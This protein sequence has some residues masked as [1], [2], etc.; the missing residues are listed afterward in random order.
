MESN[1]KQRGV[2]FFVG[3][4]AVAIVL[5]LGV[6]I[7][8]LPDGARVDAAGS[9]QSEPRA[10]VFEELGF[11]KV[12]GVDS[13]TGVWGVLEGADVPKSVTRLVEDW[14]GDWVGLPSG[15]LPRTDEFAA[16]PGAMWRVMLPD[17]LE[18]YVLERRVVTV[19]VESHLYFLRD[20]VTDAVSEEPTAVFARWIEA[21]VGKTPIRLHL[22]NL[23]EYADWQVAVRSYTHNGTIQDSE[24]VSFLEPV[25]EGGQPR[26]ARV[27]EYHLSMEWPLGEIGD[28]APGGNY[29]TT[30][31][32]ERNSLHFETWYEN[33]LR[34][35]GRRA[36]ARGS[37]QRSAAGQPFRRIEST[38]FDEYAPIPE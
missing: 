28:R 37:L 4:F 26:L 32:R 24:F 23:D 2:G 13:R 19:G 31:I 11:A 5:T 27:L 29:V 36:A 15:D 30:L 22:V 14:V 34:A 1:Q 33:P 6:I 10:L 16:R 3:A 20:S 7:D 35:V 18:L 12:A 38:K 25:I 8:A 9:S 21:G 17:E